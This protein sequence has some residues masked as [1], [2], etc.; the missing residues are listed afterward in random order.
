[1]ETST[2]ALAVNEAAGLI[3]GLTLCLLLKRGQLIKTSR[4]AD[5]HAFNSNHI[6]INL[7]IGK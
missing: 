1:M 3:C 5:G 6:I 4:T 2:T 7:S